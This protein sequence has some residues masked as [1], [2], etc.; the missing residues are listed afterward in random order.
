MDPSSDSV[1]SSGALDLNMDGRNEVLLG[2][3]SSQMLVFQETFD[4]VTDPAA[5]HTAD[6][7][8]SSASATDYMEGYALAAR[9]QFAFPVYSMVGVDLHGSGLDELVVTT[10]HSV[11]IL[12]WEVESAVDVLTNK[13]ECV[14]EIRQL[15][16]AL[17]RM[18]QQQQQ[19]QATE[20][21]DKQQTNTPKP[22]GPT[23]GEAATGGMEP[24][25]IALL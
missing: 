7:G 20:T 5:D 19:Q 1:L 12:S 25:P 6:E 8:A 4:G 11:S 14:E 15:E 17:H 10:Q 13:L 2:T 24:S 23:E 16:I 21:R 22:E 3:Y 18:K 9:K